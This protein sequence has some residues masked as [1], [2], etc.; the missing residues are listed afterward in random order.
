[1]RAVSFVKRLQ[2]DLP[3]TVCRY[4]LTIGDVDNDGDN[5]LVVG[6]A[7]GE[8]YIFKGS[9]LWQKI[10]GLGLVTSVAIGD[11]FNYGRNALVVICGDG[12]AHIYYSPRSVNPSITNVTSSQQ[13]IKEAVDQDGTKHGVNI[14]SSSSLD[15]I[16]GNTEVNELSGKMECVHVQR[17]PTNTKM[18]L[19]ADVDKDGANEMI[20]GLTDRVVRS[21]RW[22]S[23]LELGRGKLVGLNKWECANQIGT[24]TLQHMADGTPTLLVAQPG[25]TFMRIKCNPEDCHLEDETQYKG[26][27]TAASCVDYQTLGISRMRNQNISTE[28]IGDLECIVESKVSNYELKETLLKSNVLNETQHGKNFKPVSLE[29]KKNNSQSEVRKNSFGTMEERRRSSTVEN[30]KV[31]KTSETIDSSSRDQVDGNILG[32]NVIL[33]DYDV[34]SEKDSLL[35]AYKHFSYQDSSD[36]SNAEDLKRKGKTETE[37]SVR[38]NSLQGKPYALATLD[39]TIML[40]KDE[41]ILWS[42]QVDHQIFALCRLD[43]TGDGS[44]EIVACAWDGQTYILDQQRNSVRFQ[45]EEPVR[46]FC[47]GDY[48]VTPGF[49]TPCL[50]YNSFNNKIF[51]YYDVI[52]PSMVTKPFNPIEE[53]DSEEKKILDNL[54]GNCTDAERQQKIQELTECLLYGIS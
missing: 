18:V 16:D 42:M 23:N 36:N 20:L 52:L 54:L 47:T 29:L 14:T 41:V 3:G 7:E 15:Q 6:T 43:V 19:V 35:P 53:L 40:V 12:W 17:I 11:I 26:N 21:Y 46:A 24:V 37:A 39:G 22:S 27:E 32:G 1:M 51:L 25:G 2:W 13:L 49:P 31:N 5:E 38:T 28:I 30:F 48:N 50:V 8:L 33:G 44:D 45:F 10:P 4:G 9:E 34:K